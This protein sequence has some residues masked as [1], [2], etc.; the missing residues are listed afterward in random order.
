M[1]PLSFLLSTSP[2]GSFVSPLNAID[3]S[4]LW[5]VLGVTVGAAIALGFIFFLISLVINVFQ[6]ILGHWL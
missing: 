4:K 2:I 1:H 6:S 3:W 5:T